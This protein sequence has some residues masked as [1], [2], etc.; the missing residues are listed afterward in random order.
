MIW[1]L[2]LAFDASVVPVMDE[3]AWT[4]RKHASHGQ[5]NMMLPTD[6]LPAHNHIVR[7]GALTCTKA[8]QRYD[9]DCQ[10]SHRPNETKISDAYRGRALIGGGMV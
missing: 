6:A 10:A 1:K 5:R 9:K 2:L 8:Q 7:L 4:R 3:Q